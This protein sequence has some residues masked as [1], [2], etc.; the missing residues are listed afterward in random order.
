MTGIVLK[1]NILLLVSSKEE[2][3]IINKNKYLYMNT[4]KSNYK[5]LEV[6]RNIITK[7]NKKYNE[8]TIETKFDKKYKSNDMIEILFKDKKIYLIEMFKKVIRGD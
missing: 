6:K 5:I 8:I 7:G 1:D 4:K 3:I 2:N